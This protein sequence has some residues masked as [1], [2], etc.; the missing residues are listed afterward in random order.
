MIRSPFRRTSILAPIALIPV[1]LSARPAA[2]QVNV[3]SLRSDLKQ[4]PYFVNFDANFSGMLGN[5]RGI[6]AGG[7]AFVGAKRGNHLLFSKAQVDYAAFGKPSVTT[8]LASFAHLRYNYKINSWLYAEAF[9]QVQQDKFQRL[10]LRNIEGVG[11]RFALKESKA[12]DLYCGSAY[13]FEY[14]ALSPLDDKPP[15]PGTIAHRWSNYISFMIN[16]DDRTRFTSVLYVQPRFDDFTDVRVL[17]ESAFGVV[18]KKPLSLKLGVVVRYDS[19]PPLGVLPVDLSFKN[20]F[21]VMF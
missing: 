20:S 8:V 13:M 4:Q 18:L 1:L 7:S 3:E 5:T 2:A 17:N 16:L 6:I 9:A 10:R 14:E 21:S 15:P 19:Q 11:P 12:L